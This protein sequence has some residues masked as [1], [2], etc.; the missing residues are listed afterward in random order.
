[1]AS[2]DVFFIFSKFW[3]SGLKGGRRLGVKG[4]KWPKMT[5][6]ICLTRYLHTS[7][8][9]FFFS[10]FFQNSDFLGFSKFIN[11]C[12]KEFLRCAPP[13]NLHMCV[14]VSPPGLCMF[15]Q[16]KCFSCFMFHILL[17]DQVLLCDCFYFLR[18]WTICVSQ[19][20]VN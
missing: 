1:M 4:K 13:R 17:A 8:I 11:K 9:F 18:Y 10:S 3:F 15:F 2:P 7:A 19:L 5:N 20:F 16:E 6:K 14:R 12:Q